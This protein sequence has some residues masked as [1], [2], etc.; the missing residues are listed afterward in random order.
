MDYSIAD[1]KL[2]KD[3]QNRIDWAFETMDVLKKLRERYAKEKPLAGTTVFACLHMTTETANLILNLKEAGARM[4]AAASNPLSTQDDVCAALVKFHKIPVYAKCGVNKREFYQYMDAGLAYR[5]QLVLDD[6]GDVVSLVTRQPQAKHPDIIGATEETTT[7]VVRLNAIAREGKLRFPVVAVN[8]SKTK[9]IFDN[10]FGVGQSALDGITRATNRLYAGSVFVVC[11]YGWCGRGLAARA[12]GMGARVIV[13]EVNPL[14]AMEAVMNGFQVMPIV[15]AAA[16]GDIFCSVTG[17]LNVI[18]EAA[19]QQMKD[20]A[21]LSQAGHFNVEV[22]IPAL[23]KL[24]KSKRTVRKGVTQYLLRDGRRLNLLAEGRLV[25]L[26]CAEGHPASV[27]DMSFANQCLGAE[28]LIKNHETLEPKVHVLPE[29][30]DFE[31]ARL[32]LAAMGV[33]FDELTDE[34]SAYLQS[35]KFGT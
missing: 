16:I 4:V 1:L 7:G 28:H 34:Q 23:E 17:D 11:G 32:K 35:W 19:I 8:E 22:E 15:K 25:N 5:P 12:A 20:G 26:V 14:K 9:H 33:E 24:K 2:A 13:T 21:I 29:E 27:M 3:G 31:I 6:G 18:H 10:P 30:V